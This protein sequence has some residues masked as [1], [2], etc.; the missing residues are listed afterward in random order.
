MAGK[1]K[2]ARGALE[3]LT[4][5]YKKTF[6]PET[7]YHGSNVPDIKK[8]DAGTESSKGGIDN[9]GA[10]YFTTDENYA[11]EYALR[12]F[13][14]DN[15]QR[16][17][18]DPFGNIRDYV[19]KGPM[20][21][22]EAKKIYEGTNFKELDEYGTAPTIYPVK[23][24]TDNIFD[25]ENEKQVDG[26]I[27]ELSSGS[28]LIS[29]VATGS[30][31]S[32]KQAMQI[33]SSQKKNWSDMTPQEQELHVRARDIIDKQPNEAY[34]PSERTLDDVIYEI[35]E[36]NWEVLEDQSIQKILKDK[37]YRGYRT[38][39]PG[40][41]G[42]FYPDKGDVRSVFAKFDPTKSKSGNILASV[43]AGALATGAL[44]DIVDE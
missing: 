28:D 16:K 12:E 25:F 18:D 7:Y 9:T 27:S 4:D 39:E 2:I 17:I 42:L 13:L 30:E 1:G 34:V 23:I 19:V 29:D 20:E 11:H 32:L 14:D 22:S 33:F 40:T 44:S 35:R 24:K 8:F 6:A 3:A 21:K 37:G 36:G 5:A 31:M 38:N 43:P 26:L 41:I 10:T 15:F